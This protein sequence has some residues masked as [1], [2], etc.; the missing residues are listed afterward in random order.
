MP[1]QNWITDARLID[2]F[3][4]WVPSRETCA[5]PI[6][7]DPNDYAVPVLASDFCSVS[8]DVKKPIFWVDV[9]VDRIQNKPPISVGSCIAS[10]K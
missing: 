5:P 4:F 9:W 1:A 7:P 3:G 2:D 6:I 8:L 10:S